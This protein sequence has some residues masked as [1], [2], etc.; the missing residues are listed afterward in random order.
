M[1]ES[2]FDLRVA[3]V[4][5]SLP[6]LFCPGLTK[7]VTC[8]LFLFIRVIKKIVCKFVRKKTL[9]LRITC[10]IEQTVR[11]VV[12]FIDSLATCFG[13]QSR[14]SFVSRRKLRQSPFGAGWV[15]RVLLDR[16]DKCMQCLRNL[17]RHSRKVTFIHKDLATGDLGRQNHKP[18]VT[19]PMPSKQI[20]KYT[21]DSFYGFYS[22]KSLGL[23]QNGADK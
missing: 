17:N 16:N 19:W 22:T 6:A 2:K 11:C 3:R 23:C 20:R 10:G 1:R 15:F 18:S 8:F 12:Q 14:R 5:E 9:S 21:R 7:N 4:S 13:C